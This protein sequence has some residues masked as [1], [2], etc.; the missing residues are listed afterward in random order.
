MVCPFEEHIQQWEQKHGLNYR[1]NVHLTKQKGH[2]KS[3]QKMVQISNGSIRVPVFGL[4]LHFSAAV[5]AGF[6][7]RKMIQET[8]KGS[9]NEGSGWDL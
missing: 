1:Q 2:S 4:P 5:I 7:I 6:L 3:R 9:G 8:G